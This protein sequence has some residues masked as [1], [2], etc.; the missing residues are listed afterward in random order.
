MRKSHQTSQIDCLGLGI[1]PLDLIFEVD[2]FPQAGTKIDGHSLTVQGGGPVPGVMVGLSRMGHSCAIITALADDMIGRVGIEELDRDGVSTEFAVL[3]RGTSDTALGLTERYSGR[4]T[5]VLSRTINVNSKDIHLSKYPIPRVVH[6]D[7]RDLD[8][9]LKLARWGKRVGAVISLDV[10]SVRNDVTP[11]FSLV[12]HLVV[13]DSFALP[14]TKCRTAHKAIR[15]LQDHCPGTIVI[16]QGTRGAVGCE[17]GEFIKQPA[18]QVE[19]VDTTGAG[20][21]F[22]AGY[23][24]GI[25]QSFDLTK[26]LQYGAAVAALACTQMGARAGLPTL[27]KLRTFLRSKPEEYA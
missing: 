2:R 17:E 23:V 27:W 1:T 6:I 21:A 14:F 13:A 9:C 22:H 18:F 12:D 24:Y 11:L 25:L 8:A 4:R 19:H 7:G 16:T 20:D 10:G 15:K 5:M 3:K 26:R